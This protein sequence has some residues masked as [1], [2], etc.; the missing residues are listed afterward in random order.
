[1][2]L[3]LLR[4]AFSL[5]LLALLVTA[6]G[7]AITHPNLRQHEYFD[8][9]TDPVSDIGLLPIEVVLT[10]HSIDGDQIRLRNLEQEYREHISKI[11]S[12][13]LN[14]K[15]Y[16]VE[17]VNVNLASQQDPELPFLYSSF[18]YMTNEMLV[19][20]YGQP[21]N[22]E[23]DFD[24]SFE[25]GPLIN[26]IADIN[27]SH[28]LMHVSFQGTKQSSGRVA[29]EFASNLILA[30]FTGLYFGGPSSSGVL[31]VTLI[32]GTSGQILWSNIRL[33][34]FKPV[35]SIEVTMEKFPSLIENTDSK[36]AAGLDST[37]VEDE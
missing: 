19:Y 2:R 26:P 22:E 12:K 6:A 8:Q 37:F 35:K 31:R 18:K 10:E 33:S 14:Q 13:I 28:T 15:G 16:Q 17:P 5:S 30:L 36:H 4:I 25:L 32:D 9:T 23:A 1:M 34:T 24:T 7:C 29:K 27:P 20:W 21:D 3:I 11:I